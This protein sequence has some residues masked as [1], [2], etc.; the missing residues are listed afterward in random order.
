[1]DP[2]ISSEVAL[3]VEK[4]LFPVKPSLLIGGSP[5]PKFPNS[6][7]KVSNINAGIAKVSTTRRWL[8]RGRLC[9][10]W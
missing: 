4:T 1:M 2:Y 3:D 6:A 7:K 5:W 9:L 10:A 8:E